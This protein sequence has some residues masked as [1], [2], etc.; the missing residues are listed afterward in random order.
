MK[1]LRVVTI[2]R[3]VPPPREDGRHAAAVGRAG[4]R[5]GRDRDGS[6][7]VQRL[8]ARERRLDVQR[9][10]RSRDLAVVV[11]AD[12]D[13]V[14]VEVDARLTCVVADHDAAAALLVLANRRPD[15]DGV[16][17]DARAGWTAA[18]RSWSADTTS[19]ST[20][21]WPSRTDV[22]R[23]AAG[24]S[25]SARQLAPAPGR[26]GRE[27]QT[28]DQPAGGD[29]HPRVGHHP[30]RVRRDRELAR[31]ADEP[32]GDLAG[33]EQ[34]ERELADAPAEPDRRLAE[35]DAADRDLSDRDARRPRPDRRR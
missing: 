16:P 9:P 7:D 4:R 5:I 21:A 10:V 3:R 22:M 8:A 12:E 30:E 20:C 33:R 34:A 35:A 28:R 29:E 2:E 18:S 24:E 31:G 32:G 17:E 6:G 13:D 25:T 27:Q 11:A 26:R 23:V 19:A 1:G 14:A 15:V